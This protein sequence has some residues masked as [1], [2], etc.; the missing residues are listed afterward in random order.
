MVAVG[1]Q[2]VGRGM[3]ETM[4]RWCFFVICCCYQC[5]YKKEGEW[6]VRDDHRPKQQQLA[7]DMKKASTKQQQ[8]HLGAGVV[9]GDLFVR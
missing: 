6:N 3:M 5:Q 2:L 4:Q 1:W 9:S 8:A 7:R